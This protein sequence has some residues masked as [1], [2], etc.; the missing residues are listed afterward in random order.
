MNVAGINQKMWKLIVIE[1]S[2]A[3]AE[4]ENTRAWGQFCQKFVKKKMGP[5]FQR[6]MMIVFN[7][8]NLF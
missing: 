8:V 3:R 5:F 1:S 6:I 7:I 2:S 4:I